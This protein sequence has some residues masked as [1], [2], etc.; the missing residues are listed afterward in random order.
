MRK[1]L[2]VAALLVA[3]LCIT[4]SGCAGLSRSFKSIGSDISGGLQRT[5]TVY[6]YNGKKIKS[7]T[8]KIDA[9][10]TEDRTVFDLDGKRTIIRGGIVIIQED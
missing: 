1:R 5:V 4:I 10:N 7:W 2:I 8:G 6:D 3:V 9:D